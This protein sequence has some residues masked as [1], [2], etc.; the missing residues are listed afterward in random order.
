M[1][2]VAVA[3]HDHLDGGGI[4]IQPAHV[5]DHTVG[6][7]AGVE[8][9][10]VVDAGLGHGDQGREAVLGEEDIGDPAAFHDR[11]G[12]QATVPAE[13]GPPGRSLVGHDHV[14]DVVHDRG[15]HD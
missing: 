8:E 13:G 10:P 15:D 7:H 4:D 14:G 2:E 11:A 3:A 12:P 9:D 6:A 1:V 5:V